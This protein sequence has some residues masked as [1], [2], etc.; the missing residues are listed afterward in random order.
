MTTCITGG[1][2]IKGIE[3]K[4]SNVESG[5]N[6]EPVST[7]L[8]EP[9]TVLDLITAKSLKGFIFKLDVQPGKS[10]YTEYNLRNN[11][12]EEVNHFAL[13]IVVISDKEDDLPHLNLGLGGIYE[14]QTESNESFIDESKM[15]QE[16]WKQTY[17]TQGGEIAP[18]VGNITLLEGS[19][20]DIIIFLK[21]LENRGSTTQ[22]AKQILRYLIQLFF[23]TKFNYKLGILV[24]KNYKDSKI[25][26]D[27]YTAF[28]KKNQSN[29]YDAS[30]IQQYLTVRQNV[31]IKV[32]RLAL[33]G[34][35]HLDFH[36]G[37]SL[38]DSIS[39]SCVII[40]YGRAVKIKN[41]RGEFTSKFYIKDLDEKVEFVS[42]QQKVV[43]K[44]NFE[45]LFG[46]LKSL[47]KSIKTMNSTDDLSETF[48][49]V[50]ESIRVIDADTMLLLYDVPY[51]QI[52]SL[53]D[54]FNNKF[55]TSD[56]YG[57]D[58]TRRLL[59]EIGVLYTG[60]VDRRYQTIIRHNTDNVKDVNKS[61]G[62][63]SVASLGV[64]SVARVSPV[65][66]HQ[67][68]IS[69]QS[70]QPVINNRSSPSPRETMCDKF[71][72]CFTRLVNPFLKNGGKTRKRQVNRRIAKLKFQTKRR[73]NSKLKYKKNK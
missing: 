46:Y 36:A 38:I 23:N 7:M 22:K 9:S 31:L 29:Q 72:N 5:T 69:Q 40:D 55:S 11:K 68:P 44:R 70:V 60:N 21:Y 26:A 39:N 37:N 45:T 8:R 66:I 20:E 52:D 47:E 18:S 25:F 54:N 64:Q 48:R 4:E 67:R 35:I 59:D 58:F 51:A 62:V 6:F 63:Q 28:E 32:L 50:I 10:R 16:I 33:L 61:L 56:L 41:S 19:K 24:M 27:Y 2:E 42:E 53:L 57:G 34:Y 71:G 49:R 13:K 65:V 15:Q 17:L 73:R 43:F 1:L 12:R 3:H 30:A 14:K